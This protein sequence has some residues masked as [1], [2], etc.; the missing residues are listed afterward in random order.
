MPSPEVENRAKRWGDGTV[1]AVSKWGCLDTSLNVSPSGFDFYEFSGPA[2]ICYPAVSPSF[3]SFD[4]LTLS[5]RAITALRA[6][7]LRCSAVSFAARI[8]PPLEPPNFPRATA[9]GFFFLL[10]ST[11]RYSVGRE[12]IN[13]N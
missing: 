1:R 4:L 9:C 6:I 12:Q 7:V 11:T 3:F 13:T 5:H 2:I 10:I 8:V